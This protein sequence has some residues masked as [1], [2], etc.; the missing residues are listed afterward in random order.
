MRAIVLNA[1]DSPPIVGDFPPPETAP[2]QELLDLIGAGIHPVE[3]STATGR[4]YGS[5]FS[6]PLIPGIDA[7][8]RTA[9]GETVYTGLPRPPWGTMASHLATRYTFPLPSTVDPLA[10]AAG[11]NPGLSGW[12]PLSAQR[13][14]LSDLGPVLVLGATGMAGSMAVHAARALGASRVIAAGVDGDALDKL[15]ALGA[16]IA[17]ITRTDPDAT[18]TALST[19]IGDE[20]PSTVL[21]YLWGPTAEAAFSA[22]RRSGMSEDRA[23]ISY[24]QIGSLAG[25]SARVPAELLRSRRILITGSGAGATPLHA[26]QTAI[27]QVAEAITTGTLPAPYTAYPMQRIAD[28]WTHTGPTRAVIVP[29]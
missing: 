5:T 21:E 24:V 22:L 23:D 6:Y 26:L 20:A 28:A 14:R 7:V 29:Q 15:R 19:A 13:E 4:H 17:I 27:P 2:G 10:I 16:T 1:P 3:R 8:A 18:Q 11:M 9:A 25:P 12:I